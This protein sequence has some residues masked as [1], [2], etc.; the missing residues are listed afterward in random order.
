MKQVFE[1]LRVQADTGLW[2]GEQ[3]VKLG[4]MNDDVLEELLDEQQNIRPSVGGLVYE[5]G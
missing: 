1:V 2:F 4:L 3:A 5:L